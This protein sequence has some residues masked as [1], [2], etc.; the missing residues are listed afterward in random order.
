[1]NVSLE[2]ERKKVNVKRKSG[3][4]VFIPLLSPF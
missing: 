2:K 3:G 1:M 4:K